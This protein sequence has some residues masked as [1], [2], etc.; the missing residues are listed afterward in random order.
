[1]N[2]KLLVLIVLLIAILLCALAFLNR[3]AEEINDKFDDL[4][5]AAAIE[6]KG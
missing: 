1:M 4:D 6:T 5:D 3:G 2:S